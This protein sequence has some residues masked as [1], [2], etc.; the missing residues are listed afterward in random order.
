MTSNGGAWSADVLAVPETTSRRP[1]QMESDLANAVGL[2][3]S[4]GTAL[5]DL[6][7]NSI[8][9]HASRIRIRFLLTHNHRPIG[10]QVIDDGDG[11]SQTGLSRAV[12]YSAKRSYSHTDLGHFGVGLKAAS[13]SQCATVVIATRTAVGPVVGC[14]LDRPTPTSTPTVGDLGPQDAAKRFAIAS[15]ALG[16]AHGTLVEWQKARHFPTHGGLDANTKW[17]EEIIRKIRSHLGLVFHRIITSE[18]GPSISIDTIR[19]ENGH[20]GA[21]RTVVPIN[22]FG[23]V[24]SGDAAYPANLSVRVGD[25][26]TPVVLT[27]HIWPPKSQTVEYK[28]NGL[29]PEQS[30]GFY[31]YRRNRLLQ[32][33]GWCLLREPR[34]EW[35]LARLSLDL[36]DSSQSLVTINPEKSGALLSANLARAINHA[37]S[38]NDGSSFSD[39]LDRAASAEKKS[40]SKKLR[41]VE[42]V[43]PRDG[44]PDSVLAAYARHLEFRPGYGPIDIRWVKLPPHKVFEINFEPP[45][46]ELNSLCRHLFVARDGRS[47]AKDAPVF[48]VLLHLL[49]EKFFAGEYIGPKDR[50]EIDAWNAIIFAAVNAQAAQNSG[51][52][53]WDS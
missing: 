1:V 50:M 19:V 14:L 5:A 11:M 22:P 46:I 53:E 4:L 29:T 13:F 21:V 30:Q 36:L 52:N 7:D 15:S 26:S 38:P 37:E 27:A 2:N 49:L 39:F 25:G 8:D 17:L 35:A 16:S 48:K 28:L 42:S 24:K 40:R 34:S 3:H 23:Y 9:A 12:V 44:L 33:G 20:L 41:P 51:T 45:V 43:R 31:V 32:A 6:V 18:S 47:G 10:L